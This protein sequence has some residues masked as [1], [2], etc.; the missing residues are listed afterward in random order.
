[1]RVAAVPSTT[2]ESEPM[3]GRPPE[4]S[5]TVPDTRAC[6][7][8]DCGWITTPWAAGMRRKSGN[9]RAMATAA[10]EVVVGM[11]ISSSFASG[12]LTRRMFCMPAISTTTRPPDPSG[13]ARICA[14][15]GRAGPGARGPISATQESPSRATD[16]F[17]RMGGAMRRT[18][19][20]PGLSR[21]MASAGPISRRREAS[22][23][24]SSA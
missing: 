23:E 9:G 21:T 20:G 11:T 3:I 15:E 13:F 17:Q 7:L 16:T 10:P 6:T 1:M 2:V 24:R 4:T 5:S 22:C 8:S 18:V 12:S 19:A 14:S